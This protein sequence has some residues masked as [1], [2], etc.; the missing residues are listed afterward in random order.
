MQSPNLRL[1]LQPYVQ[2]LALRYPVD[3][4][5][6]AVKHGDDAAIL[7]ATPFSTEK[8]QQGRAVAKLEP[9]KFFWRSPFGLLRLFSPH[10]A[11]RFLFAQRAA[12]RKNDRARH[13][14]DFP[15]EFHPR[16]GS[17]SVRAALISGLGDSGLV[18]PA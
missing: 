15:K 4:L 12:E 7:P 11:G 18:L 16:G 13:R 8:T 17:R 6:L 5:L 9:R 2:L 1:A 10:P 14:I 3:D